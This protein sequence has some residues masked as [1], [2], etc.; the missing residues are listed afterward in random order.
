MLWGF[1]KR[2]RPILFPPTLSFG[3]KKILSYF[4]VKARQM[5]VG[6]AEGK[7]EQDTRVR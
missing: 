2:S 5:L 7:T 1:Q 6:T 4:M 3:Y